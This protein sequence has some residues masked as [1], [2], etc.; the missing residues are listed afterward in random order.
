MRTRIG[1]GLVTALFLNG[2]GVAAFAQSG[3]A[4]R[5]AT[6]AQQSTPNDFVGEWVGVLPAGDAQLHLVLHVSKGAEDQL[7]AT[8]DSVDQQAN[9]IPVNAISAKDGKLSL[10][11]AAVQGTY[12]GTLNK[13]KTEIHGTW[14]QMQPLQLT[15]T[16]ATK[17]A[18]A[19]KA[20]AGGPAVAPSDAEGAWM[21]TVEAGALKLRVVFHISNSPEGLKAT[22]DSPD[23]GAKGIPVSAVTLAGA[24]LKIEMKQIDGLYEGK[25]SADRATIE[26]T[27]T[28]HGMSRSLVLTRAKDTAALD[29]ISS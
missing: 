17:K 15:F 16:R 8:L 27:W 10:V 9:G 11:V 1:V 18:Q 21:G 25:F 6:T 22:M 5:A 23:Q 12:E 7:S 20:E 14:T 13:E 29:K 19:T 28:Q 4:G 24:S 3:G 26:G 2:A